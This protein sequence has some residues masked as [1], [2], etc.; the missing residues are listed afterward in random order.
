MNATMY[1]KLISK[2]KS[3]YNT[4]KINKTYANKYKVKIIRRNVPADADLSS[5][6]GKKRNY[7]NAF[8]QETYDDFRYGQHIDIKFFEKNIGHTIIQA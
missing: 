1:S 2:Y 7:D 3:K 4:N 6:L 5:V 8:T